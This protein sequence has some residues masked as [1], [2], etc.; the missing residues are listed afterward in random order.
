MAGA[1]VLVCEI[2][3]SCTL[4]IGVTFDKKDLGS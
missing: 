4:T 2:G 1:A 3:T